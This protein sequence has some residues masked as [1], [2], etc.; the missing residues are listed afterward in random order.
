MQ[1]FFIY[2]AGSWGTALAVAFLRA[3]RDVIIYGRDPNVVAEINTKHTNQK[4]LPSLT[5]PENLRAT[6]DVNEAAKADVIILACPSQQMRAAAT[7]LKPSLNKK[8]PLVI[9][10][11]G[12]EVDSDLL[13]HEVLAQI[14]PE[15]N[16]AILS[17]PSF[18]HELSRGFPTAITLAASDENIGKSL[19]QAMGSG[20]M[21]PYYTK[22]MVGAALGGA[23]K[24]VIAIASG[25]VI[26]RKLGENAR[27]ALITRGLHEMLRLVRAKGGDLQTLMGLS[28]IG[29]LMLTCHS[30]MSRNFRFG[31][32]LGEGKVIKVLDKEI[33][34]VVEGVVTS[35]SVHQLAERLGIEA[36][37]ASSVKSIIYDQAAIDPIIQSL[38]QRPFKPEFLV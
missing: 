23:M 17:G 27:A 7:H 31:L 28:G 11:K 37:I 8:Q 24:N 26:G 12:I 25:I 14:V 1:K 19:L 16:L 15:Q 29:D 21:R 6:G 33:H 20:I 9:T 34:G 5:L 38:M 3:G 35:L 10:A 22:D 36:P 4:Y 18:A 30:T 13:M 2:G 32:G